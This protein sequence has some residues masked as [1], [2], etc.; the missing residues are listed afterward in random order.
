DAIA[1]CAT[2]IRKIHVSERGRFGFTHLDA[3]EERVPALGYVAP[4]R[5]LG[6]ALMARFDATGI[7]QLRPAR[8]IDFD[9]EEEG[10]TLSVDSA[11]DEQKITTR[12]LVAADGGQSQIRDRLGIKVRR[13]DYGHTAIVSNLVPGKPH[14]NIAYERFTPDGPLALLPMTDNRFGVVLTV[15]TAEHEEILA[16]GDSD[17]LGLLQERFGYRC[18]RFQRV[19]SRSA[20]PL[21]LI[22]AKESVR[23]R[24]ALLGNAA[25]TLHPISGQGF[26]LGLR[27]VAVLVDVIAD[28]LKTGEDPGEEKILRAYATARQSDQRNMALVTDGL[29]RL[30][31]NPLSV[32]T[33]GRNIGLLAADLLP[34]IR[35][36]IARHAMGLKDAHAR[37]SRGLSVE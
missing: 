10:I 20:Y 27:D 1:P 3:S 14:D 30:F 7:T 25:H 2:P 6:K 24:V 15:P 9:T 4:A 17:F 33:T 34:G 32:I 31:S 37:L 26:N 28:A 16:L 35:H 23:Q 18:G 12:L 11:G 29:A 21:S 13:W 22:T 19:G 36:Q 8:L 5:D